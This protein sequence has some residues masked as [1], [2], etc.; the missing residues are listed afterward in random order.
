MYIQTVQCTMYMYT[1]TNVGGVPD[2]L[3]MFPC[4]HVH[5]Y[6]YIHVHV[7]SSKQLPREHWLVSFIISLPEFFAGLVQLC[8]GTLVGETHLLVLVGVLP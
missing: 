3:S 2:K 8:Q 6:M 1:C 5:M 4:I 7:T